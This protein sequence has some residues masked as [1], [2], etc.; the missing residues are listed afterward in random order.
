MKVTI[1]SEKQPQPGQ[2]HRSSNNFT[3]SDFPENA[4]L[5]FKAYYNYEERDQREATD[6]IFDIKVDKTGHDPTYLEGISSGYS[7]TNTH[8]RNLYIADPREATEAFTVVIQG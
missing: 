3:T 2:K 1:R 5:T 7:H 6:V 4:T 8:H